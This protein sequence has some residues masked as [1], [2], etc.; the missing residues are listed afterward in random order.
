MGG[1]ILIEKQ[2]FGKFMVLKLWWVEKKVVS[3]FECVFIMFQVDLEW[4]ENFT[5]II[6]F[7]Q[8]IVNNLNQFSTAHALTKYSKV[9]FCLHV[10]LLSIMSELCSTNVEHSELKK[11]IEN[12]NKI[13]TESFPHE[14]NCFL[15]FTF[16]HNFPRF[17]QYPIS[18]HSFFKNP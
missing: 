3:F 15:S 12:S 17:N 10:S 6:F 5:S 2:I 16:H 18:L 9:H 11:S 14:F 8:I 7:S 13:P 1:I 4:D